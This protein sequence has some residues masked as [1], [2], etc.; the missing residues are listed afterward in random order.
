MILFLG[1][2]QQD[3]G[4]AL[5][6]WTSKATRQPR[7]VAWARLIHETGYWVPTDIV[8]NLAQY[9]AAQTSVPK[10]VITGL[11]VVFDPRRQLGDVVTVSS[12]RLL[13]TTMTALVAGVD[14]SADASGI[15]RACRCA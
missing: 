2:C 15:N 3:N 7:P 14:T 11:D 10:P 4:H 13:G 12:T 6:Q 8:P 9:L 5:A 1:G